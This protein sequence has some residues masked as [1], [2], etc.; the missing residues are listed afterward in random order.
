[1]ED[2]GE[3]NLNIEDPDVEKWYSSLSLIVRQYRISIKM[4]AIKLLKFVFLMY[5]PANKK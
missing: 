5:L 1:M 2:E 4:V 3:N